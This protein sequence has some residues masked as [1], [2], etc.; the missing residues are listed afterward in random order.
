MRRPVRM[1]TVPSIS[2]RRIRFGLPTSSLPSGVTV[3][4]LMPKP[5]SAIARAAS[6]TTSFSVSR[7]FEREVE[8]LERDG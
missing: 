3:A 6:V 1:I 8:A 4:A 5:A 2:S 7:R